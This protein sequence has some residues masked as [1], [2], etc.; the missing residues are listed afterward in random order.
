MAYSIDG[1][2]IDKVGVV[3]DVPD[4]RSTLALELS[5]GSFTPNE[6]EG[7]F[8]SIAQLIELVQ[9]ENSAVVCDH[10]FA[11]G[12]APGVGAE[13]VSRWYQNGFPAL[14]T[15][16][17]DEQ[18]MTEIR[19]YLKFI[20]VVLDTGTEDPDSV[21]KGFELCVSEFKGR[22]TPQRKAHKT[23]I[24]VQ[25]VEE[26]AKFVDVIVPTWNPHKVI[27]LPINIFP[28]HLR[29]VVRPDE[30]FF[31]QVN[32]GAEKHNELYFTDFEYKGEFDS[33]WRT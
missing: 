2:I 25:A 24:R 5:L 33:S 23:L 26:D 12:Y 16:A 10:Q 4:L 14:L 15:T 27:Q 18:R 32:I 28:S 7:P 1:F 8:K 20:P 17:Y 29:D 22:F 19:P 3:D 21:V 31:A 9:S 30:R 13:A 6:Y 11:N